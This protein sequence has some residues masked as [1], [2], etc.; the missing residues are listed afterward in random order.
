M[1]TIGYTYDDGGRRAA[2]YKGDTGDC[3]VRAITIAHPHAD[4]EDVYRSMADAIRE[5][6]YETENRS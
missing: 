1:G 5:F 2:G 3:V 6:W 4:Y